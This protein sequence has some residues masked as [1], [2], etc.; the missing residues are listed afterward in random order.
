MASAAD[1]E[2]STARQD[3]L[4]EAQKRKVAGEVGA[5]VGL[6]WAHAGLGLTPEV[7][8]EG[9]VRL[10]LPRGALGIHVR[11]GYQRFSADGTGSLPCTDDGGPCVASDDGNYSWSLIE[12][13]GRV[14]LPL[15]YR[16]FSE[17]RPAT[18]YFLAAPG[19]YFA[20]SRITSYENDNRQFS[21]AFGIYAALGAQIR[22]GPGGL[23]VEAGYQ[24]SKLAHRITGDSSLGALRFVVGYRVQL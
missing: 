7:A 23:F 22:L 2:V 12:H 14:S 9:G 17:D 3:G 5:G 6:G 21:A 1:D 11:G 8:L 13:S 19:V 10:R 16:L 24:W 4:T 18:P 15:S 20:D